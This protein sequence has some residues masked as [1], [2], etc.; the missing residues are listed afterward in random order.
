MGTYQPPLTITPKILNLV[1]KISE[2]LGRYDERENKAQALRLRRANQIRTIQG[3][4]AIEGNSLSVEQITAVLE[5]KPVIAPPREVQEVKNA[6]AVYERFEQFNALKEDDLLHAHQLLMLGLMDEAGR[7]R[8]G[9]VGVMSGQE[10]IHMA[11]PA[12]QVPR[13]M[14]ALFVWL[15]QTDHH[16]LIASAV[17]HY[18]FEFIHPFADGNGRMGRLWQSVILANWNPI[19]A[20]LPVESLIYQHQQAYYQAIALS[21]AQTDCAAFVE[22]MLET[23]ANTFT[24]LINENRLG[25]RLGKELSDNQQ[26]ILHWVTLDNKITIKELAAQL[27]ISTTAVENNIKKLRELALLERKGGRKDGFWQIRS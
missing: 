12:N 9:G 3:S 19:F 1:A 15:K 6:L 8:G 16:A 4:L 27:R 26:A 23:I 5:G 18:E 11:P 20:N 14:K 2:Q 13:L 17:F 7:Y 21:T 10:V 24:Q 25:K 22:F